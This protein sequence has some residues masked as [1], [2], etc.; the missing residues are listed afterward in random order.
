[1]AALPEE[2]R[3][4]IDERQ[5]LREMLAEAHARHGSGPAA[6]RQPAGR[7]ERRTA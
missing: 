6:P 7:S 1:V 2:Y 4:L 3:A 5:T